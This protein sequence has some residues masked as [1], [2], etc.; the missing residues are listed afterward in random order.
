MRSPRPIS[1][2]R[3]P[4]DSR[5]GTD[6]IWVAGDRGSEVFR[7]DP[8]DGSVV[9]TI[10][11]G[12][13]PNWVAVTDDAVWVEN[14]GDGTVSR[15]DPASNK[16]T[17]LPGGRGPVY[18][19]ATDGLLWVANGGSRS[20]SVLDASSGASVAEIAFETGVHGLA[21]AAGSIWVL[22]LHGPKVLGNLKGTTIWRL[23][24]VR[25]D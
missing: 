8:H 21:A 20:V 17:A 12:S 11:V 25:L 3:A 19:A 16:V 6:A 9:A 7:V 23:D 13:R 5:V 18:L 15:I 14:T 4:T 10:A 24:P 1:S 22:D 2:E